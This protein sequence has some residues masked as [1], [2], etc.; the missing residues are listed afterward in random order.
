MY[1]LKRKSGLLKTKFPVIPKVESYLSL[2]EW[3][4]LNIPFFFQ[5]RDTLTF[6]KNLNGKLERAYNNL[7]SGKIAFF[8]NAWN[9][10]KAW[11]TNPDTGFVYDTT[12]H[13]TEVEDISSEAGDIKYVWEKSRFSFLN[14][15]IRYDYHFDHDSSDFV[16]SKIKDWIQNNPINQGPNYKC[17]QEISLRC[18]N[19][20]F[21][22]HF[23]KNSAVLTE[24]LWQEIMHSIDYQMRH[25]YEN[26][27]FSRICVR[28]NHAISE[29]ST[30]YMISLLFPF[31]DPERKWRNHGLK[32]LEQEVAYQIYEDGTFLQ[33]SHNYHRVLI[34]LLTWIITLSKLHN[35]TL[36]DTTVKRAQKTLDYLHTCCIG[37]E[38][39]LPNYGSN[40][41]ALFFNLNDRAYTD[42]RPQI[43]ALNAVL[44]KKHIYRESE[45]QEDASW[46]GCASLPLENKSSSKE[47]NSFNQG[48][49]YTIK[50]ELSFTFFKCAK[51]RDRPAHADNMHLDIWVK[52]KNYFRDS[53]TYKYNTESKWIDYFTGSIGHNT[54]T[55][56]GLSQMQKGD[57]FI[58][59]NWTKNAEAE[60]TELDNSVM[61]NSK[62]VMFQEISKGI[63]HTR[64]VRK[65]KS[66]FK[67]E[68]T[69][70]V[71][72]LMGDHS[73][74]Q[75]WHPNPEL[76]DEIKITA[77]DEY[78]ISLKLIQDKG[79]WSSYYGTKE[80]VPLWFFETK[81]RKIQ[82]TIIIQ[83]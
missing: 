34:Q 29:T 26:I 42:F 64:K 2:N 4:R 63:T 36:S 68:V 65:Q 25:V 6:P 5:S 43:N 45:L 9:E 60:I 32:W 50:D 74:K 7:L 56:D 59:Y 70:D 54:I 58:W 22:L 66:A 24:E 83:L 61:I 12:K 40:D 39:E 57:R 82:T 15:I 75:Y 23:Y 77:V 69:D 20:A 67:W 44:N 16:F 14:T 30:L 21:V 17:S 35:V 49:I 76:L 72:N 46:F 48:G 47:T 27:N 55:V 13:W 78:G 31:L 37:A 51:Y 52:G 53:G 8:N 28:N 33:F 41:G 73:I 1:E 19:W 81:T 3:K 71:L 10:V 62:A 18:L 79:Q 11:N 38:G 80:E